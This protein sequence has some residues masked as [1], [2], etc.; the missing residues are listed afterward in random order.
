MDDASRK[1]NQEAFI[2]EKVDIIVSTVAFGMGIDKSNVRFVLHNGMPKSLE[3]Y[4]QES[5]RAGRD[6]LDAECAL[7]YSAS[8]VMTWKAMLGDLSD[9]VFAVAKQKLEVMYNYCTG[10]ACRH[11]TMVNYYGQAYPRESCEACDVCLGEQVPAK[12]ALI[13]A[14]KILSC[15]VRIGENFGP[16]Y[17]GRV[18][19]GSQD[20]RV[21]DNG[22]DKLSTYGIL[23]NTGRTV[24]RTWIE[25][26]VSQ[27]YL[28]L[29]GEFNV[30]RVTERGRHV[31]KGRETPRLLEAE[32]FARSHCGAK[33][34]ADS[35]EGVDRTLFDLLRD[36][37]RSLADAKGIPAFVVFGDQP[38]REMARCIP[39]SMPDFLKVRGVGERKAEEYGVA[40]LRA[41]KEYVRTKSSGAGGTGREEPS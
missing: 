22:H 23:P 30:L 10:T 6:G 38:L 37:R 1:R 26:L 21:I 7:L 14:Q 20:K 36:L 40:F 13:I 18:L 4:Q 35:W 5:G 17:V 32:E 19:T 33:P 12:D 11:K 29:S 9:E 31:L 39:A 27:G 2:Q 24:I 16:A 41:I 25:Q 3:H 15:V 34:M 8:D 28:A